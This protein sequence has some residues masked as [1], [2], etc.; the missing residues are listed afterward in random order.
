MKTLCLAV[1]LSVLAAANTDAQPT[2]QQLRTD[3]A[4][5]ARFRDANAKLPPPVKKENR[6]VFLGNS[7]TEGWAK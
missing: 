4:N 1:L 3:W 6:V 5:L 7:I 2:E